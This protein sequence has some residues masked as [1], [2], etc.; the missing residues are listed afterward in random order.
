M[1]GIKVDGND[2]LAV[3]HATQE[4]RNYILKNNQPF[5]IEA[6]TYRISDHSTSDNSLLYR[7]KEELDLW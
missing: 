7:S 5:F 6:M 2:I 3:I 4:A 1:K